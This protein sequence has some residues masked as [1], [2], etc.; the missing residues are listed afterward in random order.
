MAE[1]SG[2]RFRQYYINPLLWVDDFFGDNIT[3]T[4]Q[5]KE[6]MME[7]G[8][9]VEAKLKVYRGEKLTKEQDA[10]SK[11]IGISI[12]SGKGC[13]ARGTGIR[14]FDG[15]IKNVEDVIVGDK[16]MGDDSTPREVLSLAR[17][18]EKMYRIKYHQNGEY[19]D[20][21]ESHILSL[22]YHGKYKFGS[23]KNVTVK[24]YLGWGHKIKCLYLGYKVAFE[25]NFDIFMVKDDL[26][27]NFSFD[28][29]P[30]EVDDYYGFEITGNHLYLLEDYTV[31]HNTGKDF[32]GA[33][34]SLF[35]MMFNNM[36]GLGT[37]NSAK[38]LRNVFWSEIAKVMSL[39][40]R[41]DEKDPQSPT[42]L[43]ELIEWQT[44]KIYMK[45]LK[46][47]R[48]FMEAVTVPDRASEE[49]QAKAL[50]GRHEDYMCFVIDEAAGMPDAVFSKLEGTLTGKLNLIVMIF[51]PVRR[52]G[53][54]VR[55]QFEE[56]EKWVTLRWNSEESEIVNKSHIENLATYGKDSNIYR[57]DVLGL[58]PIA[59]ADTLIPYDWVM[60]AID[61]ETGDEHD[62]V[63][64]G[65][66]VGAG[67]DS[68]I[69][70][71][72]Q[73]CKVT[74][75]TGFNEADTMAFTGRVAQEILR[76]DPAGTF[77]DVIGVGKGVYDRLLEQGHNVF[78][79]D[80]RRTARSD[81]Y[82]NRRDELA[83]KVRKMFEDGTIS[84]PNHESLIR[85]LIS[86]KTKPP[87]SHGREVLESKKE[88]KRR[89][90]HSP[91]EFDA[92]CM[93]MAFEDSIFRSQV[94]KD[95]Y[96]KYD[97]SGYGYQASPTSWMGGG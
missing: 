45:H 25:S 43:E 94:G 73:G 36:K 85:Q 40:K 12:M 24:D 55:S 92:L 30:L 82:K 8:K 83:Q 14:M 87:D 61:R 1:N 9:L 76:D 6:G 63:I 11:K 67:G 13:H 7:V 81:R 62:P 89:I 23:I 88:M 38:Q 32:Y 21:N 29:I 35:F 39:S 57:V 71:T 96:D 60:D 10:Y 70:L 84:I 27:L 28:V 58:P 75:I 65:V 33:L 41:L 72:R 54:A 46:G 50:T 52:T 93:S 86:I 42:I 34:V 2:D 17:G 3:L 78:A 49:D 26:S 15:S 69:I 77:I 4:T 48:W 90:G 5:Q 20:V 19:Y 64:K 95:A 53:F 37:A 56:K 74:K 44:E 59:E 80:V 68:S 97:D 31:T 91:D 66:D 51:N 47:K 18:R 79:V 22:R 16:L